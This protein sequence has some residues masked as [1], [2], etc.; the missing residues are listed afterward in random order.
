MNYIYVVVEILISILISYLS[1]LKQKDRKIWTFIIILIGCLSRIFLIEKFPLGLNQDEASIGYEAYSLLNYGIDRNGMP[2]PVNFISWGSGQNVLYAYLCF[3]FIKLF[4]LNRFSIRLP[5][6]IIGCLSLLCF[7]YIS[8]L[9]AKDNNKLYITI[10]ILFIFNPWHIMK[11]RWAL[12]SNIFPDLIMYGMLLLYSGIYND[13]KIYTYISSL[14]LGVSCYAYGTSYL[15]VSSLFLF[16]Y[17]YLISKKQIDIKS[18]IINFII[19][20]IVA[21]PMILFVII[22]YFDLE[23]IKIGFITIPKLDYNR[24]TTITSVN[25]NFLYNCF[26]NLTNSLKICITGYDGID[27]NCIK[28]VGTLYP[29]TILFSIVGIIDT[30]RSKE[31]SFGL[32]HCLLLSSILVMNFVSPNINRINVVW[33]LLLVYTGIGIKKLFTYKSSFFIYFC[34]Y[35]AICMMLFMG[36]YLTY[37]QSRLSTST[38]VG[39]TESLE[40][41][42]DIDYDKA[43]IT[44]DVNQPYIFY[45]FVNEYNPNEYINKR[46][47]KDKH[48]MFQTVESIGNVYF[49]N[50]SDIIDGNAYIISAYNLGL[51]NIPNTMSTQQFGYYIVIY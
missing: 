13:K 14:I 8:R 23:T 35:Y 39:F 12:E 2:Y 44:S 34:G 41:I 29:F 43:Y 47:I 19:V 30:F 42:K 32:I 6:A 40:Y 46:V 28:Y 48:V 37:Y 11:S 49:N 20:F 45:L 4:G 18:F 1:I 9:I 25:G 3:P 17:A 16:V 50:P 36:Y 51:Y 22:N 24:F 10:L 26:K 38:F 5:M 15:Y 27:L 7:N 33:I 21:L 31:L